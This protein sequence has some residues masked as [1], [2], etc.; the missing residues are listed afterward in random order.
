MLP[1]GNAPKCVPQAWS[2]GFFIGIPV[3]VSVNE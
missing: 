2:F 3:G 1:K